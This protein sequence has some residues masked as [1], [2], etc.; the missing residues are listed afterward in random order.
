MRTWAE[1]NQ[2][3]YRGQANVVTVAE[4]Q[5]L[6]QEHGLAGAAEQVDVIVTA[7]FVPVSWAMLFFRPALAQPTHRLEQ[8][9][10]AGIPLQTGFQPQELVLEASATNNRGQQ[11][12]GGHLLEAWLAGERL[13]LRLQL[14]P[15]T[16]SSPTSWEGAIGLS[17]LER[18]RLLIVQRSHPQGRVAVNSQSQAQP[19]ELGLLLPEMR[20]AAHA[21]MGP[22][23]P[24]ILDPQGKAI[25]PGLPVLV[26][27]GVGQVAWREGNNIALSTELPST[28]REYLRALTIPGY[29]IGLAVGVAWPIAVLDPQMLAPLE[30]AED[31]LQAEVLDYGS[32]RR[33]YPSLGQVSYGALQQG[34]IHIAGR[35]IP[36][37]PLSSATRAA[38]MAKDL[39]QRLLRREFPP[40]SP[41]TVDRAEEGTGS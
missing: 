11:R 15:G 22:W 1:I 26:A 33:P 10:L 6:V 37:T 19:S 28:R 41:P 24:A 39:E 3:L 35:Q 16:H 34:I 30:K 32:K 38:R 13:T 7:T 4:A 12:G 17:D 27:G 5:Q 18:A 23:E 40:L 21:W 9:W 20:N 2:R 8:A 25:V 31:R 14:R 36:V 29:A